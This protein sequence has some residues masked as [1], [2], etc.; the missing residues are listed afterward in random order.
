MAAGRTLVGEVATPAA[1]ELPVS[2]PSRVAGV[3]YSQE[4]V[5]GRLEEVGCTVS[6]SDSSDKLTV[7][8]PTWRPDL[9]MS[10]DLVEEILRLEGLE[11]I[12]VVLPVAPAGRGLTPRQLRRRFVG[13]ALAHSGYLEILPTPFTANDVFDVWGLDAN[14]SRRN[15]VKII[16]PLE[17]DHAQLGSTLLPAMLESLKRNVA[18]GQVDVAIYGIEQVSIAAAASYSPIPATTGLP[19]PEERAEL[20]ASLP[21]QPLHVAT[22][23]C[24]RIALDTP[25]GSERNY[26]VA[27]AIEAARTV[28]RAA[29][30]ELEVRNA[31]YLP[32]H[33]GRCAELLVDGEVIGH[34]GELHPKVCKDAGLPERTCAME[35]NLDA[36]PLRENLAAPVL[37]PFPAVHQ[38]VA[39]IVS[40]EVAAAEVERTLVEGAGELLESIRIFDVY[41]SEQLG[42]GM[43]SLAYSLRFRA[44]DR[45]LTEEEA[46]AAREAAIALAQQRHQAQH[47]G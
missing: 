15:T 27:D 9:T 16:N 34:A 24:G 18:R 20:A 10:A 19:S 22:V 8:P 38:D 33:P 46:S 1:I 6:V 32:W 4:T 31:E 5:I 11:A 40:D 37:S 41:R 2:R 25:W 21:S 39:L 14:D 30:V 45:T 35:L 17:S 12:P 7:T 43:R 13:H 47:R 23:A 28:A 29:N 26:G 3:E 42:E 44:S 36:L